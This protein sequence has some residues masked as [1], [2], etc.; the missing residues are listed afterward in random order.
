MRERKM[1][2]KDFEKLSEE[3]QNQLGTKCWQ[4]QSIYPFMEDGTL[5][6]GFIKYLK[7]V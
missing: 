3:K 4:E 1:E 7:K 6:E 5:R 2:I